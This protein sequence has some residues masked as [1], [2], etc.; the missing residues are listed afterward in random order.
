MR[1][2]ILGCGRVGSTLATL[3]SE[4]GH[5]VTIV[6][7]DRASFRRL[8]RGFAGEKV[9]GLGI[10]EDVLIQAGI[11]Q[12]DVFV[13]VSSGDNSN[14]MAAQIARVRFQVPKVIARVYD[15]I[16]AEA[17]ADP[18]IDT[19]CSTTLGASLLLNYALDRPFEPVDP[20]VRAA[21]RSPSRERSGDGAR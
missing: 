9:V 18:G 11:E 5:E 14:I 20:H 21:G 3:A 15:P 2:V 8:G 17:Y 7:Q 6:D 16:R 13:A 19:Y 10:G 1:M 4:A 12:A